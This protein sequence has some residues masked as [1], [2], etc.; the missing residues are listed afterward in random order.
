MERLPIFSNEIKKKKK[1]TNFSPFKRNKNLLAIISAWY[2]MKTH[3]K[4]QVQ[5]PN[6]QAGAALSKERRQ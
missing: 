2:V 5:F 1:S 3:G 6:L 4:V